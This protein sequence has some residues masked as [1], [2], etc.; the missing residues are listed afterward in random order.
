MRL[1]ALY[2]AIIDMIFQSNRIDIITRASS[3]LTRFLGESLSRS[4]ETVRIARAAS[5]LFFAGTI[6]SNDLFQQI[7]SLLLEK[8]RHDGGWSDIEETAWAQ[9]CI[10]YDRNQIGNSLIIARNWLNNERL[11]TGGWGRH[12]RDYAR[13]PITSLISALVPAIV[14]KEDIDWLKKEW[15]SDFNGPVRLSYKAGFYLLAIT[16]ED[17][18]KLVAQTLSH[19]AQDQN[20]DGGFAPWKG[21][22]IASEA[23]STGVVLWGLSHWIDAI[24][25]TV[26]EKALNWL[27]RAQLP[28]G[29]WPYHYLDEGTSFALIGA[30]A[31]MKA[32][33][34][35]ERK[36]A[37]L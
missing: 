2:R 18:D 12:S 26:I 33:A 34:L 5:A 31:A 6:I 20:E 10:S 28:S 4:M 32:L 25:R 1:R 29:Y 14:K 13:I 30:V 27:E 19:L 8:Q 9:W 7:I 37:Q 15:A 23:W 16:K 22:P 35:S 3:C 17:D 24:D 21:H 36:C 11:K